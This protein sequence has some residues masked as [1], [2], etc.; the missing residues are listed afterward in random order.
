VVAKYQ[1]R[2]LPSSVPHRASKCKPKF[3]TRDADIRSALLADLAKIYS[4][5]DHDL[6]LEEF[7]CNSARV[8]VAVINE[9]LQSLET[10]K[11]RR[12]VS[13]VLALS[14]GVSL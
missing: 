6:I 9:A 10:R 14:K 4:D 11:D 8:D 2:Y 1:L 7:G 5:S 12:H 3:V 13:S